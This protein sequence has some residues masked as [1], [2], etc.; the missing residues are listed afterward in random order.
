MSIG[1]SLLLGVLGP[2]VGGGA[3]EATTT[4][5]LPSSSVCLRWVGALERR[6]RAIG[7]RLVE[8]VHDR[9]RERADLLRCALA[10][11]N[12]EIEQLLRRDAALAL[13]RAK[14]EREGQHAQVVISGA[15]W[16]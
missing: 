13:G 9:A 1:G 12:D 6:A 14:P 8:Q 2:A 3:S 10:K 16:R 7:S 11:G 4:F 15:R 5:F